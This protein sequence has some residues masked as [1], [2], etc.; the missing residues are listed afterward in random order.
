MPKRQAK[1]KEIL[2]HIL[3]HWKRIGY[4]LKGRIWG[5]FFLGIL[6]SC[7]KFA[8]SLNHVC[9]IGLTVSKLL[10]PWNFLNFLILFSLQT[11]LPGRQFPEPRTPGCSLGPRRLSRYN[12]IFSST[13]CN[14]NPI[15]VFLFR[16]FRGYSPS[17]HIHVSVSDLYIPRSGPH[18]FLLQNRQIDRGNI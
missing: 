15:Y 17:I 2:S 6:L 10:L 4:R 13:H 14:E 8:L 11:W 1:F 9:K 18:I 3:G 12:N 5:N 7:M 16:E